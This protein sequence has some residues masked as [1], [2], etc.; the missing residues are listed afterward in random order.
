VNND[1]QILMEFLEGFGPEVTG[2]S[3]EEP[4]PTSAQELQRFATGGLAAPEIHTVCTE[5][6]HNPTW[7]RYLADRVRLARPDLDKRVEA[8]G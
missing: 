8:V 1:F 7:I 6:K 3:L 4:P 2:R 5:L